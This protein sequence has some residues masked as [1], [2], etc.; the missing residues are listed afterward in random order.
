MQLL[1]SPQFDSIVH[2]LHASMALVA[3]PLMPLPLKMFLPEGT[4]PAGALRFRILALAPR[5]DHASADLL[6]AAHAPF[7]GM[8]AQRVAMVLLCWLVLGW[9]FPTVLLLPMAEVRVAAEV[10]TARPAGLVE[11]LIA[12]VEQ[13]LADLLPRRYDS[14]A[15]S[16]RLKRRRGMPAALLLLLLHWWVLLVGLW[17]GCC[18]VAPAFVPPAA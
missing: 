5:S 10:R 8:Y 1:N 16:G 14:S 9:V 12:A 3:A 6:P 7:A 17:C 11:R 4:A 18:F 15:A 2:S 13:T